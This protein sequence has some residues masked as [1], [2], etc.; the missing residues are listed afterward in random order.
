MVVKMDIKKRMKGE[1]GL[2]LI[3]ILIGIVITALMM[4]A[5]YTSYN[6][7]NKTYNQVSEKAKISKTSRDLVSMLMRD[8][9]MAG[10]KYYV[11]SYA[12]EKFAELTEDKCTN[13]IALP[14]TSYFPFENGY[15]D[16]SKSHNPIVIRKKLLGNNKI[17]PDVA[18]KGP[19]RVI[20]LKD[21]Q[22][23]MVH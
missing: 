19:F 8:V 21:G 9:R 1:H 12:I 15:D 22:N 14:K 3:E 11:G 5:M 13:G 2:T 6:V 10:Y 7:V 16:E 17:T 23:M 18:L 4:G 20:E